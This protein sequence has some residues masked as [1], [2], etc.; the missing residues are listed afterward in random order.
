MRMLVIRPGAIGDVLLAF[1]VIQALRAQYAGAHVMLVSNPALL[2]LARVCG[3]AEETSDYAAAQWSELFLTAERR[4]ARASSRLHEALQGIDMAVCWLKDPDGL[5]ER[6]LRAAG[7][8]RVIV[9]PGRPPGGERIH[10]IEYLAG[11]VDLD[12]A[13]L[14]QGAG[15]GQASPLPY[16]LCLADEYSRGDPCG[17]PVT[18]NHPIPNNYPIP[19]N[20]T[21]PDNRPV[22]DTRLANGPHLENACVAL[23]P[24]S[25]GARKCWPVSHFATVI[26]AL[27]RRQI[28]VLLLSGSADHERLRDLQALLPPPPQPSLLTTLVEAPLLEVARRLQQ[29][30]GYVGND[31]G[32]THLAALLGLP[33]IA[34]FGASDP[35]IWRPP[36]PAVTLL[37][38]PVLENLSPDTVFSTMEARFLSKNN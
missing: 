31:S 10:I 22:P 26:Q 25:G 17:R 28:P 1:P 3:I 36:G 29:C 20:R 24:G 27:W 8:G 7:I 6:N 11:T 30:R 12:M 33:T 34:I 32:I 21:A 13:K 38:E 37:Y 19:N 14:G 15:R 23:H 2:P 5:V 18:D 35:A 9:A 4:A 16:T